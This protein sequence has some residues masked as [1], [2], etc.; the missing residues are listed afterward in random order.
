[1]HIEA[2]PCTE[3]DPLN[4][5]KQVVLVNISQSS[6]YIKELSD[7]SETLYFPHRI[8]CDST[9]VLQGYP[10]LVLINLWHNNLLPD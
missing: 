2:V 3:H 5:Q 8:I 4:H 9:H 1:M 7:N 6:S 10:T